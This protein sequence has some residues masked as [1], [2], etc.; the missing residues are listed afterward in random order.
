M[1]NAKQILQNNNLKVTNQ[2]LLMIEEI[3]KLNSTFTADTLY[4]RLHKN[5]DQATIYRILH[6]FIQKNIITEI[7]N[8]VD[9][10]SYELTRKCDS[11]H[12]HLYCKECHNTYCL[13]ELDDNEIDALNKYRNNYMI[14]D[15]FVQFTGKCDKCK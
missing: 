14:D 4:K 9:M 13:T 15:I 5:I 11:I 7:P 2:R 8:T 6:I 3:I 12:P 1:T 10:K